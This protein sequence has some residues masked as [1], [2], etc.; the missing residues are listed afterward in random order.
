MGSSEGG[1]VEGDN[2]ASGDITR[3]AAS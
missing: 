3:E 2:P 1:Y